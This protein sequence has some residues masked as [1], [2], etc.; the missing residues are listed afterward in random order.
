MAWSPR[1]VGTRCG[2]GDGWG[3]CACPRGNTI[4]LGL[5]DVPTGLGPQWDRT[6]TRTSARPPH[7]PN[8]ASLSLQDDDGTLPLH[9]PVHLSKLIRWGTLPSSLYL[10]SGKARWSGI[11]RKCGQSMCLI[12]KSASSERNTASNSRRRCFGKKLERIP[13]NSI[14]S[15]AEIS[16]PKLVARRFT[17]WSMVVLKSGA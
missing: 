11:E 2:C 4:L 10:V 8:P 7:P 1:P 9:S 15:I 14:A 5:R 16:S 17:S 13:F 6:P 3:P 12:F